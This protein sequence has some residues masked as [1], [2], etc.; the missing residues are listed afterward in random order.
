MGIYRRVL[1][2]DLRRL[3]LILTFS[4]VLITLG[5]SYFAIYHVQRDLLIENTLASNQRYAEKVAESANR[6]LQSAE[7]LVAYSATDLAKKIDDPGALESEVQRLI[8]QSDI[9][10]SAVIVNKEAQ[11]IA[12]APESLHLS[13]YVLPES[14]RQAFNAQRAM[15]S[16]PFHSVTGNTLVSVSHPI[17]GAQG[18][19]LGYVSGTIYLNK[20]GALSHLL[21]NQL[22]SDE[23]YL[24]VVDRNGELLFHVDPNR[25][26]QNVGQMYLVQQS[27]TGV[28]GSAR[29][30][31]SLGIDML[32]GFAPISSSDWGLVVQRP[33][34]LVLA[35]LNDNLAPVFWRSLPIVFVTLLLVWLV[36]HWI[37]LP[38][39]K[40]AKNVG[41]LD[42]QDAY[43][44]IVNTKAWYFEASQ[45]KMSMLHGLGSF[46][47]RIHKLDDAS[48]KDPLTLLLNR[49]GMQR[50]LDQFEASDT[51]FSVLALDIDHFKSVND[52][53]GHDV[54]DQVIQTL[55]EVMMKAAGE[56]DVTCRVG[57]EEFLMFLPHTSLDRATLV[58]ESL[59]E[60]IAYAD[61]P[62][63]KR[64]TVSIGVSHNPQP[65]YQAGIDITL[66]RAD[67][68]LYR[69]KDAGRNRVMVV[70]S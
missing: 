16:D 46:N 42:H 65:V 14:A 24:Y 55:G 6:M 70:E 50:V 34:N 20:I 2:A 56:H 57:G 53:F 67:S 62:K 68:A 23:S 31:N 60:Q 11:I 4:S 12:V 64:I 17:L 44:A 59:C 35:D 29:G 47:E 13:G 51:P 69:A 32:A 25:I 45:L 43:D 41:Q 28:S 19:Y 66:K 8:G 39:R 63:V 48:H 9:F 22:F 37:T 40:L 33:T 61:M 38:L 26:G 5:N 30:I 21:R 15:I 54:G 58:A 18:E 7:Q 3:V 1:R 27:L 49:R 36:A 10:N 52:R